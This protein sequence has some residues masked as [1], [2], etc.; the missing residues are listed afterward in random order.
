MT[1]P[2]K[3]KAPRCERCKGVLIPE[4]DLS[5]RTISVGCPTCGDRIF[6]GVERRSPKGIARENLK[7]VAQSHGGI[8]A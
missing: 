4:R 5:G 2:V 3:E 8:R 1:Q 6:R 7:G